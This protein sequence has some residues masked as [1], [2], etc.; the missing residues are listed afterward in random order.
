M[1]DMA[2][3]PRA[4]FSVS[5]EMAII[6]SYFVESDIACP[7]TSFFK[8]VVIRGRLQSIED[9][10]Q[11]VRVFSAFMEKLQPEG[12]YLPFD[13]QNREY[14]K[15]VKGT[16]VVQLETVALTAKFKFGQNRTEKEW[17]ATAE[18]LQKRNATKDG[19]TI[20]EMKRRCPFH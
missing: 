2:A 10:D 18:G 12:G 20:E 19:A 3:D 16:S 7:A 4:S 8:S 14:Y 11:K 17:N 13:L 6:P 1:K 5:E 9:L 15:N